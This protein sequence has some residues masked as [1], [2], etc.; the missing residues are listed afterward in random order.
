MEDAAPPPLGAGQDV[1]LPD[2]D[3]GQSSSATG[4]APEHGVAARQDVVL[5]EGVD[6]QPSGAAA[7]AAGAAEEMDVEPAAGSD[8]APAAASSA[9]S[10]AVVAAAGPGGASAS[11][12]ASGAAEAAADAEEEVMVDENGVKWKK[13]RVAVIFG[14]VGTG[15]QG[16]QKC[17]RRG[18]RV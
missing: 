8:G 7:P 15:Y 4:P 14:Y 9:A 2:A 18:P 11:S 6:V 13:D 1:V 12:A 5:P 3:A 10:D 16:L 17:V